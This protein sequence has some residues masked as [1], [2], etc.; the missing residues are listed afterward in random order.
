MD[1]FGVLTMV[2]GLALFLYGMQVLGD[3]LSK[4]SGGRLEQILEKLTNNKLK[5]V[6][7]GAGVTA[8]IQSSS[9]TTV[10]VVGFVNSGIM[11]LSQAIGIIMGAN[12]GTTATSWILSLSGI[13]S[14]NFFIKLL[15]PSSFSPILALIGVAILLFSKKEKKKNIALI[16]VGFA[17]LMFGMDTMSNAVKPLADVPEFTNILLMF[18]NP[19]LGLLAGL[20]LTA[21]IQSS[22]ASV[23]ILQALCATGAVSYGTAIPI[24]MGQNIGTCIT[25]L[26]SSIG[27][28][29]N[30]RR[31]AIVHLY[32]NIIGTTVFMLV[33]Y[34]LNAFIDFAFLNQAA[35]AY[36]IAVV[37]SVFNI[38]A[39]CLLLPFSNGLEKL[40]NLTI[41]D[42]IS[43]NVVIRHIDEDIKTL[44]SRFINNPGLAMEQ[45]RKVASN[46]ADT[47]K[48]SYMRA[49]GLLQGYNEKTAEDVIQMEKDIDR[50]EDVI[51]TYLLKLGG[52][53]LSEKDS[54]TSM[55]FLQCIGDFERISDH[56]VSIVKSFEE[57][58]MKEQEFSNKA[59]IEL[60]I[61]TQAVAEMLNST[62]EVFDK[63]D[64]K[65]AYEVESL[66]AVITELSAE[67]RKRHI[68]RLRKGKCTI[69]LGFL[70]SD[71][72]TS[73]ERI[74]AHC[75]HIVVSVMQVREESLE[76]HGY[77]EDF[78]ENE[79]AE[80]KQLQ[81]NFKE[82]YVLP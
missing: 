74:A 62:L 68:K 6:L 28:S 19:I 81:K 51:G 38:F 36:G 32:F 46:M 9:A 22:S 13:E 20:V 21:V 34:G 66:S 47:A 44:D 50:Y 10:M 33:F 2:G 60:G 14:G 5:A 73:C 27:T 61:F 57:M 8:V 63:E 29:K 67:V 54:Q 41:K 39:T 17:V 40:A 80:F 43:E 7:L 48:D 59:Q 69:E 53:Q 70:L 18:S 37:H 64:A 72:V 30:A 79:T 12:I 23:G 31:A 42:D 25:A 45:C 55:L 56:A 78:R 26:L 52:K 49:M 15:K 58:K 75:S 35:E 65:L 71:I 16:L 11:K 1:F 76:M 77:M 82:K 3:G 24:I 4:V